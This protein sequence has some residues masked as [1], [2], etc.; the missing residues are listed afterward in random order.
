MT[1]TGINWLQ[2][3]ALAISGVLVPL[4]VEVL[5]KYWPSVP[6]AVKVVTSLMAGSLLASASIY[7]STLLGAPVDFSLLEQFLTGG[8]LGLAATMGFTVAKHS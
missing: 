1:E 5:K 3:V 6:N 4:V 2:Y 8:S 7:L